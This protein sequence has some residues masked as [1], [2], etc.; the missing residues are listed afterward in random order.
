[1]VTIPKIVGV[2]TCGVLLGL[3]LSGQPGAAADVMNA[4]QSGERIGGQAG[5]GYEQGKQG[6]IAAIHPGERIGGQAGQGFEQGKQEH[7]AAIHPGER[8]GGQAGQGYEQ[9]KQGHT[10]TAHAGGR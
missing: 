5:R 2:I 4:G 6:H 1:M 10:A 9:G 7:I 3:G 8:I